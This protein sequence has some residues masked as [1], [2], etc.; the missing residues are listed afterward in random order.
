[1][2]KTR[3]NIF[4]ISILIFSSCNNIDSYDYG[5][6][7]KNYDYIK[8]NQSTKEI[9]D[10]IS[11]VKY[12]FIYDTL[13]VI[14]LIDTTIS[15]NNSYYIDT[16]YLYVNFYKESFN[17]DSIDISISDC[18]GTKDYNIHFNTDVKNCI[19]INRKCSDLIIKLKNKNIDYKIN[20]DSK[21]HQLYI[22]AC[23]PSNMLKLK[24]T[25]EDMLYK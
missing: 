12:L 21:Y 15:I 11:G 3:I 20:I 7:K 2:L 19:K 5:V 14:N 23:S 16:N 6:S 10:T 24:Y 17:L 22:L 18:E 4:V 8:N 1:M 13:Y 9:I 25:D